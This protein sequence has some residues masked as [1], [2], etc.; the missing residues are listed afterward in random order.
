MKF[1]HPDKL[2]RGHKGHGLEYYRLWDAYWCLRCRVWAEGLC[3]N[4][5][6]EFCKDRPNTPPG[7]PGGQLPLPASSN[8]R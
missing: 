6:C 3:Q 2:V 4:P 1:A 8:M 5:K 7:R